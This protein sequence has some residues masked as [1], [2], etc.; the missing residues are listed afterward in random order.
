MLWCSMPSLICS[1][2]YPIET[3]QSEMFPLEIAFSS[4]QWHCMN[5]NTIENRL[6]MNWHRPS[7]SFCLMIS[8]AMARCLVSHSLEKWAMMVF[9][10]YLLRIFCV[11]MRSRSIQ[12]VCSFVFIGLSIGWFKWN[13]SFAK[14]PLIFPGH[15]ITH[16]VHVWIPNFVCGSQ[17]QFQSTKSLSKE[18]N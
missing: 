6:T 9:D 5:V 13:E 15:T 12:F 3:K 16:H 7:I 11:S 10:I 2:L 17:N 4:I 8:S 1:H 18:L 14:M